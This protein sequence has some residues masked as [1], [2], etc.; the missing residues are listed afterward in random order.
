MDETFVCPDFDTSNDG[1]VRDVVEQADG[2]IVVV[3]HFYAVGG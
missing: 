3:G 1:Y 2:K